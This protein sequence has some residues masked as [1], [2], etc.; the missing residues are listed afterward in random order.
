MGDQSEVF[1]VELAAIHLA[2]TT[3]IKKLLYTIKYTNRIHL[4]SNSQ[5]AIQ[6]LQHNRAGPGH[7]LATIIHKQATSLA[8]DQRVHTNIHWVPGH[9]NVEGNEIADMLAKTGSKLAQQTTTT[10]TLAWLR[11]Q[12]KASRIISWKR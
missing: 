7:E 8:S 9:T 1:D 10:T 2:L 5:A 12:V 3:I 6:R 4:F 11:R